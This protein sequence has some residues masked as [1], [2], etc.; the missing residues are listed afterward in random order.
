M[1]VFQAGSKVS[2]NFQNKYFAKLN[3]LKLK[4][5]QD[6]YKKKQQQKLTETDRNAVTENP[7]K[8][9]T[10]LRNTEYDQKP[11]QQQQRPTSTQLDTTT[12]SYSRVKTRKDVRMWIRKK[13]KTRFN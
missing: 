8:Q 12:K 2:D 11:L 1:S 9:E 10:K 6:L 13:V 7:P 4:Q 5:Y 3:L